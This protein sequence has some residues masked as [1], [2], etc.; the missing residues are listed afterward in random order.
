[1]EI[2]LRFLCGVDT[3]AYEELCL[4]ADGWIAGLVDAFPEETVA[5]YKLTKA[6]KLAEAL[7]IYRW[8]LPVLELDI[9]PKLVQYIKLAA[10]H[11]GIGSPH[12]RAP[13][14][15]LTGEELNKVNNII[16]SA[17][18]V[19]VLFYQTTDHYKKL[20]LLVYNHLAH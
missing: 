7:S 16:T 3:L 12:V 13:R 14:L 2:D 20:C 8:F 11:T 17:L 5:I 18:A 10:T 9:H 15:P 1:L 19:N 6:G 4:G